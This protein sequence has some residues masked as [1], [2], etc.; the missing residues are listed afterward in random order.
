MAWH[1]MAWHGQITPY[2]MAGA[3]LTGR[4]LLQLR[5]LLKNWH[6]RRAVLVPGMLHY[7]RTRRRDRVRAAHASLALARRLTDHVLGA[8]YACF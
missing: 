6:V 7:Y 3:G 1:G 2:C 5:D 8:P 4:R